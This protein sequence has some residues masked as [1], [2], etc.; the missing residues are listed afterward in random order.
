MLFVRG[1]SPVRKG[2]HENSSPLRRNNDHDN[3]DSSSDYDDRSSR[4]RD[5]DN[6]RNSRGKLR[7]LFFN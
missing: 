3:Y 2:S 7:N 5:S 1:A 4:H 6:K